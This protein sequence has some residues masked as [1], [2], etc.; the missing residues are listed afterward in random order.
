[1]CKQCY[2]G[3]KEFTVSLPSENITFPNGAYHL[4]QCHNIYKMNL[5]KFSQPILEVTQLDRNTCK[6]V[7]EFAGNDV[8][9]LRGGHYY[10]LES[11]HHTFVKTEINNQMYRAQLGENRHIHVF[12]VKRRTPCS[13]VTM[14]KHTLIICHSHRGEVFKFRKIF[15]HLK[16][17]RRRFF[18]NRKLDIQKTLQEYVNLPFQQIPKEVGVDY[19][20]GNF[21]LNLNPGF[22]KYFSI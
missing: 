7:G 20:H 19:K 4:K 6:L 3:S 1:M 13:Y 9:L 17:R 22:A 11:G 2:P 8:H 18:P 21:V 15:C 14:Y 12:E 10:V 16:G 5:S